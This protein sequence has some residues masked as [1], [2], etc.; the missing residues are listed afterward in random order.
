MI[1][2]PVIDLECS[3]RL[4]YAAMLDSNSD[5]DLTLDVP[6]VLRGRRMEA[7]PNGGGPRTIPT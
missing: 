4:D 7:G 1:H 6:D 5:I 3:K 2:V